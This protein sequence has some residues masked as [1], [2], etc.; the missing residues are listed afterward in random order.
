IRKPAVHPAIRKPAVHPAIRWEDGGTSG[1][2]D[3]K[4]KNPDVRART[5]HPPPTSP[6]Y[7]IGL[8]CL[9]SGSEILGRWVLG[10]LP[11]LTPRATYLGILRQLSRRNDTRGPRPRAVAV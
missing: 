6:P 4:S 1:A 11:G 5:H 8:A 9:N 7:S 2:P 3:Q 10:P